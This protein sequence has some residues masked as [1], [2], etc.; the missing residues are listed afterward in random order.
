LLFKISKI[1]YQ[2]GAWA[3]RDDYAQAAKG[4][5]VLLLKWRHFDSSL[6]AWRDKIGAPMAGAGHAG[7]ETA[8]SPMPSAPRARVAYITVHATH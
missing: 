1:Y 7:N 6:A 4:K 5:K 3:P 2:T 8:L